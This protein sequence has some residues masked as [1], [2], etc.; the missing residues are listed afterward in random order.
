MRGAFVLLLGAV[1][2]WS[3]RLLGVA[4]YADCQPGRAIDGLVGQHALCGA[5]LCLLL[6]G[7]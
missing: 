6:C 4:H 2:Y 7:C 1:R 3:P 5:V